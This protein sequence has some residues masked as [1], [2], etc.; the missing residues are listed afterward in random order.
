MQPMPFD[1][2]DLEALR[3]YERVNIEAAFLLIKG[4]WPQ[5]RQNGWGRILNMV[6]GSAWTPPAGFTGYVMTKMALIGLTRQLANEFGGD[7]VTVNALTPA[8]TRHFNS[9]DALPASLYAAIAQRQAIKR[10]ATPED[11]VGAISFLVSDDAAF[12]TGQTLSC[13]GGML[14]L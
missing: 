5:M 14:L 8:L 3:R 11:I 10:S 6:S 1:R 13:D 4:C 7:G 12:M 9:G 2:L